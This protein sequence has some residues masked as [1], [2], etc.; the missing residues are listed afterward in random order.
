MDESE[1]ESSENCIL[2]MGLELGIPVWSA[3]L[4]KV[5]EQPCSFA[6]EVVSIEWMRFIGR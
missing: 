1:S 5:L 2:C 6:R 3:S 4:D